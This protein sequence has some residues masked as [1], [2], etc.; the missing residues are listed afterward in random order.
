MASE[1]DISRAIRRLLVLRPATA[2]HL[3]K[4]VAELRKLAAELRSKLPEG[5]EA[6]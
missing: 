1:Q 2:E 3:E 6:G 4:I 5:R